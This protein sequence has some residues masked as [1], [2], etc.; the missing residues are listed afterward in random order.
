V[1]FR[2]SKEDDAFRR[3]VRGFLAQ[4]LPPNWD[5]DAGDGEGLDAEEK[6]QFAKRFSKKLGE[7]KW[8]CASWPEEYGGLSWSPMKQFIFNE[9][10]GKRRIDLSRLSMGAGVLIVGPSI[11]AHGT[12][13]Q[14]ARFLPPI[15]RGEAQWAQLYSEPNAG[16]DLASIETT[17]DDMG[18]YFLVNGW[19]TWSSMAEKAQWAAMLARTDRKAPKHR[20]ISYLLLDL[21]SPG[22][23]FFPLVNMCDVAH[24]NTIHLENV[25]VPKN[26]LLGEQNNGWRAATSTLNLERSFIRHVCNGLQYFDELMKTAKQGTGGRKP[27]E[28]NVLLRQRLAQLA[29]ETHISQLFAYRIAWMQERGNKPTYETSIQK[30][31]NSE[32]TQRMVQVGMEIA[33]LHGQ[34]TLGSP[35]QVMKGKAQLLYRAQ[36]AITIGGGTSEIQRNLIGQRGLGLPKGS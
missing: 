24:F 18:D 5:D 15:A 6:I 8:L 36:R 26:C 9:E 22:I 4:E 16:S 13:E 20:G 2:W 30:L 14:K 29:I 32:M 31:F 12:P 21:K 3:E 28:E 34:L 10:L 33:G 35:H 27:L 19:K 17:A 23:H 11:I 1:D 25:V 7:R